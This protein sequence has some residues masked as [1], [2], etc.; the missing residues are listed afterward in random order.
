VGA[1][2]NGRLRQCAAM[3]PGRHVRWGGASQSE[4]PPS[5]SGAFTWICDG[6]TS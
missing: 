3:T 5:V 1:R 6:W 2:Q 4:A